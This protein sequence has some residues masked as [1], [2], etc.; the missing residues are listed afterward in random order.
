MKHLTTML[1]KGSITEDIG[2][3]VGCWP[4]MRLFWVGGSQLSEIS[5]PWDLA[6]WRELGTQL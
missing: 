1:P 3:C 4:W 6:M 2:G 5:A